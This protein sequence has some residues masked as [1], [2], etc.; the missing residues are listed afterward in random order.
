M[1]STKEVILTA[2]T[3]DSAKLLL[4]S[5]I[6]ARD[7]LQK[8]NIELV[9]ELPG[10]GTNLQDHPVVFI[11]VEVDSVLSEKYAFETDSL[12]MERARER[13]VEDKTGPLSHHNGT[14]FGAF[15]KLPALEASEEY[16]ALN[17]DVREHMDKPTIPAFEMALSAPM[18][19][20]GHQLPAGSAYLSAVIF[21][22]NP[23]SRGLLSL[24][25]SNSKD[26]PLIDVAYMSHA[27]DK[28][29]MLESIRETMNFFQK[30]A[31]GTYFKG[32]ILGPKSS[33]DEHIEV[34]CTE[35]EQLTC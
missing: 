33:S 2:G 28:R 20:P 30:S 14:L 9:H 1:F 24:A 6:G 23:Q 17:T 5:G 26:S 21:L 10:V 34:W 27:F 12:A 13:W 4:I 31:L 8:H 7:E 29:A 3:F 18:L 32:Y 35:E 16:K 22:M 19:P 11:N 25:S 15:L